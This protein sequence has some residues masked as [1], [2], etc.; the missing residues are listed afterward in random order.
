M[1]AF[2]KSW[3]VGNGDMFSISD[4]ATNA[5]LT[6]IDC[7]LK[8]DR[9]QEI[10]TYIFSKDEKVRFISTHPD[11]DHI[12]GLAKLEKKIRA[13]WSCP[14][15]IEE[16]NPSEDMRAYMDLYNPRLT[17]TAGSEISYN[18]VGIG[19][20]FLWPAENSKEYDQ[21]WA[22]IINSGAK[23]RDY[24]DISP[25]CLYK[26]E[27]GA[28]FM[29]MGDLSTKVLSQIEKKV[30]W[31]QV[32]VLFAPHH[33]RDRV[34]TTIMSKLNPQIIVIGE[35]ATGSLSI[36]VIIARY[37]RTVRGIYFLSVKMIAY[38]YISLAVVRIG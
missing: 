6:I 21:I 20:S 4:S 33:G 29:W 32:D 1:S 10:L 28:K 25:V 38:I 22:S 8:S 18:G 19:V 36:I 5:G 11:R 17:I 15:K 24:N 26:H 9:E 37:V 16:P 35:G 30:V 3:A 14:R 13:F 34:P 12:M 31:P 23:E 2:V 7:C 27:G